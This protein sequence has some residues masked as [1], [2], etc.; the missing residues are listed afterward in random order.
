MSFTETEMSEPIKRA[1][2][3]LFPT[4][5]SRISMFPRGSFQGLFNYTL[6]KLIKQ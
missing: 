2:E 4:C 5:G 3:Q 1:V 6:F